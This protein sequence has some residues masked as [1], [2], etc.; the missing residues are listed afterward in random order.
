MASEIKVDTVSEK[1][2]AN[3]VTIDGVNIKDSKITTANSIDSDVYIDG[4]IDNAH[5]ADDAIDSEHYA[6]GSIDTA[7]IADDQITLAKMASGTDGNIISYDASG[8]PV[9]IAT[10]S[11]G[12]VLTSAGAGQPPAFETGGGAWNLLSTF[13]SDGSDATASFT[14]SINST[15]KHY[16]FQFINIHCETDNTAFTFQASTDTGSSYGVNVTAAGQVAWAF[17]GGSPSAGG[18]ASEGAIADG[19]GFFILGNNQGNDADQSGSGILRIYDP[20]AGA[21]YHTH[22]DAHF[23][24]SYYTNA[25]RSNLSSGYFQ[26]G[27][28]IDAIQFKMSSGEIQGGVI[29]MYGIS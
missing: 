1:T 5:I 22:W 14:S 16:V 28:A 21:T 4:S 23:V 11:D 26:S 18:S 24:N 13:T 12:Q 19:T 27:S 3:G 25:M 17:E 9:A 20:A 10:G 7:H 2:S 6:A 8:N 15:Y 29:K